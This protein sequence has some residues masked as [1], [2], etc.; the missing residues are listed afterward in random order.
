MNTGPIHEGPPRPLHTPLIHMNGDSRDG[1]LDPMEALYLA[2][3]ES[4]DKIGACNPNMRNYYPYPDGR[5]RYEAALARVREWGNRLQL[6]RE[7]IEAD[8]EAIAGQK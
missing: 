3:G 1:L 2:I 5:A 6:I 8:V 4:L 7:E